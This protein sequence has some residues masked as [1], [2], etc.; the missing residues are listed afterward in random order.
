MV[1]RLVGRRW[2]LRGL[3][4]LLEA[5]R[6]GRG[7]GLLL[8]GEAG[9]GKTALAEALAEEADG[10]VVGWGRCPEIEAGPYWYRGR[11]APLG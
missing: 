2:E 4:D 10:W 8:F 1:E 9:I 3:V 5:A 11:A 7:H 6:S